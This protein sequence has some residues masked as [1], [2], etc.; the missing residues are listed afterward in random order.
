MENI[1]VKIFGIAKWRLVPNE[2]R[3]NTWHNALYDSAQQFSINLRYI[4]IQNTFKTDWISQIL[5]DSVLKQYPY[6]SPYRFSKVIKTI[7]GT[8]SQKTLI[9]I[10]EGTLFWLFFLWCVRTLIPNCSV[11]VNLFSSTSYD[12]K[13]FKDNKV[14]LRYHGLFIFLKIFKPNDILITFDTQLMADKANNIKSLSFQKFPVPASFEFNPFTSFDE[15]THHKVLVNIRGFDDAKLHLLLE[16]SCSFCTFVFPRGSLGSASLKHKFG[17][18]KNTLFDENVVPVSE[19]KSYIDSFDYMIFLYM[20]E[21]FPATNISGRILDATVR[22]IPV[23]VPF[24]LLECAEVARRWG[25]AKLFDCTSLDSLSEN[26]NHPKFSP[27]MNFVEP[28]FTPHAVV[29]KLSELMISKKINKIKFRLLK[30]FLINLL[31]FIHSLTSLFLSII[32]QLR[33]K[34]QNLNLYKIG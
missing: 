31:L 27:L 29:K 28:P 12:R 15:K 9:Y 16:K 30:I 21:F 5:P 18:Y 8:D 13:F 4:G 19:W 24:Q 3:H 10:F 14:K 20:P 7:K 26:F 25:R 1:S 2:P 32:F 11:I 17:K 6:I 33:M 22:G 34:I 23:C